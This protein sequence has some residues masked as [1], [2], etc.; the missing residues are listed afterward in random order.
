MTPLFGFRGIAILAED[1]P[2][3]VESSQRHDAICETF[4]ALN[5]R[6]EAEQVPLKPGQQETK[7]YNDYEKEVNDLQVLMLEWEA[8]ARQFLQFPNLKYASLGSLDDSQRRELQDHVVRVVR[9]LRE[10]LIRSRLTLTNNYESIIN[11]AD[12]A[13]ILNKVQES[14]EKADAA[15][16]LAKKSNE[17]SIETH[18]I[19]TESRKSSKVSHSLGIKSFRLAWI[20]IILTVFG[21]AFTIWLNRRDSSNTSVNQVDIGLTSDPA[22]VDS[23]LRPAL[24][25]DTLILDSLLLQDST[26]VDSV[27]RG[28]A[29]NGVE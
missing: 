8:D 17:L 20:S 23:G 25:T 13:V 26:V 3:L 27:D 4:N 10:D 11:E 2:M 5:G 9:L 29:A 12:K 14:I 1:N 21:I 18:G 6:I 22:R 19:A 15:N 28:S 7:R 24:P 16:K